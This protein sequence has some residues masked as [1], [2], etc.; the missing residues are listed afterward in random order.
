ML[1]GDHIV[2]R[3]VKLEFASAVDSQVVS[4]LEAGDLVA[5]PPL[6]RSLKA[7][8]VVPPVLK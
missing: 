2:W 8:M 5:L 1:A 3:G 4:G 7:A 6:D